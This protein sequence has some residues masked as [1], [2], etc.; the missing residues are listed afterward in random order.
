LGRTD[1]AVSEIRAA[2][3]LD[4]GAATSFVAAI[5]AAAKMSPQA[6]ALLR[7]LNVPPTR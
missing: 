4:P 5:S 7:A 3:R 6:A 1:E 2:A